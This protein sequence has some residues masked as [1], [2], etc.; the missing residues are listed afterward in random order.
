MLPRLNHF[1]PW[2]L[3][4]LPS[5]ACLLTVLCF[6]LL[7]L[8]EKLRCF[9]VCL[10]CVLKKSVFIYVCLCVLSLSIKLHCSWILFT[11]N[12]SCYYYFFKKH[13]SI[14]LDYTEVFV[15]IQICPL[16]K[17]SR[18]MILPSVLL[19][20]LMTVVPLITEL[21]CGQRL[22]WWAHTDIWGA[23]LPTCQ[24]YP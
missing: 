2:S 4:V 3:G 15:H 1:N 17:G 19:F 24:I 10:F 18:G 9:I 14:R 8:W 13:F 7:V 5:S 23:Q 6:S 11:E 12:I 21:R 16:L 20:L 22:W